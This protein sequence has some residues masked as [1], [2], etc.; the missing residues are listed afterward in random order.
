MEDLKLQWRFNQHRVFTYI[1][2]AVFGYLVGQISPS[3]FNTITVVKAQSGVNT[4]ESTLIALK[5]P[6]FSSQE[7]IMYKAKQVCEEEGLGEYCWKDIMGIAWKETR[8]N[9]QAV[10]DGG[11]SF[12]C[13]Q[14]HTGFHP[15]VSKL[16]AENIDYAVRWVLNFLKGKGYPE[17]RSYSIR[18]FNGSATNPVTKKYLD[19]INNF[20]IKN[21]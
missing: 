10:G 9:C 7:A 3:Y 15:N 19:D 1:F 8:F 11:K 6:N 18:K 4:P 14:I 2:I 13:F 5:Q 12:G 21:L 17:Y 20:I 16:E